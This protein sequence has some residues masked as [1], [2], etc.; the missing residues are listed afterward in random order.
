[1]RPVERSEIL[2]L[3][4]YEAARETLRASVIAAKQ[5]R[6][7]A[8]GSNMTLLFENRD[9]VRY[10]VQEMLRVERI[11]GER[12]ISHEL[13]TYNELVPREGELSA[14]LLLEYPDVV[15][16]DR[17][18]REL[19]GLDEKGLALHVGRHAIAATFDSR[20]FGA[21]RISSVHYVKFVMGA[22]VKA[23]FELEGLAGNVRF[24]VDH[25]AYQAVAVL[26]P[27]QVSALVADLEA[28]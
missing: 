28:A 27:A 16:R 24:V 7:I 26:R 1:M 25:P 6:R 18:L 10:Q 9:T 2:D 19:V 20:Q 13:A 22:D 17:R 23:A 21:E 8:L 4:S 5:A 12:E 11:T 14:T 3:P 15:E